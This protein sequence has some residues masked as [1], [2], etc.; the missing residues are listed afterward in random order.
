MIY[1]KIR[2]VTYDENQS[3]LLDLDTQTLDYIDLFSDFTEN[4]IYENI[5]GIITIIAFFSFI[6]YLSKLNNI[7]RCFFKMMAQVHYF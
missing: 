7:L 2:N 1:I 3:K 6:H 5:D 4:I